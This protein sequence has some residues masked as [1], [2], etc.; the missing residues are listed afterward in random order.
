MAYSVGFAPVEIRSGCSTSYAGVS[1]NQLTTGVL[2]PSADESD[3]I[4]YGVD[5]TNQRCPT[6]V[7]SPTSGF[8]S[9]MIT[10]DDVSQTGP[11]IGPTIPPTSRVTQSSSRTLQTTLAP[12]ASNAS[13]PLS[14][15]ATAQV[16]SN[17]AT[18]GL[19]SSTKI[20]I[21]LGVPL[22]VLILAFLGFLLLHYREGIRRSWF[23]YRGRNSKREL[24]FDAVEEKDREK[25]THEM[26]SASKIKHLDRQR[27]KIQDTEVPVYRRELEGSPGIRPQEL[28]E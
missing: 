5:I 17:V 7:I 20:G 3:G 11:P 18:T 15:N 22:G 27:C 6:Y 4:L 13:S 10:T 25:M 16:P 26:E 21:G 24:K 23:G 2:Y 12:V 8:L 9:I 19:S 28:P 14:L 1:S